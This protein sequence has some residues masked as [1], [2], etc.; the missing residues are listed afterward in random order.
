MRARAHILIRFL[1]CPFIRVAKHVPRGAKLLDIGAGHGVFAVLA[2]E[3]RAT[4]TAIDPDA[5]KV[6]RLREIESVIGYDDCIRG[7]FDAVALIDV[8]Y[9]LPIGDWDALLD[10]IRERLRPGGTLIIKEH[11][12]TSK[13][14]QAIN[15]F[16][17]RLAS[18]GGLTLGKSFSYERPDAFMRRLEAH[19]F[20][21][22]VVQRIDFGYPHPHVLYVAR[23]VP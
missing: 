13:F 19:G 18:V 8:L 21:V 14:K 17:E 9:K 15:R 16:Q 6:R 22:A 11:D 23:L 3:R 5:R 2:R 20:A 4:V 10:R 12:P 7:T 1:T